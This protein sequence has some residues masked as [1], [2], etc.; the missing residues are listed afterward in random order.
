V[1][2]QIYFSPPLPVPALPV[3]VTI[4]GHALEVGYAGAA[5]GMVSG[6]LQVTV[7]LPTDIEPIVPQA[8]VPIPFFPVDLRVGNAK[9]GTV[10]VM[11]QTSP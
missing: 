9:S 1:D 8:G 7:R 5:P 6:V 11:V 4:G 2:G 10:C 3:S